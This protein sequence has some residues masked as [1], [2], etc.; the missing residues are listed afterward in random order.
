MSLREWT[1]IGLW[2]FVLSV[3]AYDGYLVLANRNVMSITERNPI[4]QWLVTLN[5]GDIWLLLTAKALGTVLA[6]TL[7]LLLYWSVP[8]RGWIVCASLAAIQLALLFWL[9]WA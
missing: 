5:G 8:R 6:S 1:F 9:C 3:S 7:L 2:L 4:G